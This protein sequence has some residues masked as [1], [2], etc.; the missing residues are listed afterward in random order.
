MKK[1]E[2][3]CKE[4]KMED[5]LNKKYKWKTTSTKNTYRRQPTKKNTNGR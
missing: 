2:D 3:D 4:M 1:I 5:D